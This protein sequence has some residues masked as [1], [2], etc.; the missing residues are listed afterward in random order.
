MYI[1][2][3]VRDMF[4]PRRAGTNAIRPYRIGGLP[5]RNLPTKTD[6]PLGWSVLM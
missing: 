1:E 2:P 6:Q 5:K 3:D 4:K